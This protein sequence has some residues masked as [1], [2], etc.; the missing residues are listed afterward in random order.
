MYQYFKA[1]KFNFVFFILLIFIPL[2]VSLKYHSLHSSMMDL[3][4]YLFHFYGMSLGEWEWIFFGHNQPFHLPYFFIYSQLPVNFSPYAILIIQSFFLLLPIYFF[5]L[6]CGRI[7]ALAYLLY[8]PL[9]FNLLFDFHFDHLSVLFL[10]LFFLLVKLN[11]F[12][13]AVFF[14]IILAF[15]KEPFALQTAM[16][17]FY[18]LIINY[19]S[20]PNTKLLIY[21]I[22][23][24]FF[25]FGFFY[26]SLN[27]III[28][29]SSIYGYSAFSGS[30]FSY[31]GSSLN[32]ILV[33]I[34]T[35]PSEILLDIFSTPR[36]LLFIFALFGSLAFI[37]LLNPAPLIVALP[38]F[39]ISLLSQSENYYALGHHYTA[40]LIA[41]MI[42]SFYG[43]INRAKL[44]WS[45]ITLFSLKFFIPSITI[46]LLVAHILLSPS[47]ISRLF[48]S[49]KIWSYNYK[50]YMI[51]ERD[52]MIINAIKEHI[53]SDPDKLISVQNNINWHPLVQ[54]RHFLLFPQ[55]IIKE[56]NVPVF[57][58][59]I[60]TFEASWNSVKADYA[61]VDL[62]RP[63]FIED[64]GC[65]WFYDTCTNK[66]IANN[67]LAWIEKT[68][69]NMEVI[70]EKDGFII[71]QRVDY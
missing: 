10:S 41:P 18:L 32:E 33:N 59:N 4:L 31:L 49:D 48:W 57:D 38:I 35:N 34:F 11:K 6:H 9:W 61:V 7:V 64:K 13:L 37:P 3:G 15:V 16:C 55:G 62:K 36:K 52:F 2:M 69:N 53:P 23:L 12:G 28:S 66:I 60:K 25:G 24:I 67:F 45:N 21:S 68:R 8:F 54:R 47:P 1:N 51:Q 22:G 27:S 70:F 50:A 19:K 58:R 46:V 20:F 17:G 29:S 65:D 39:A 26:F 43:G 63:W 30:A 14:A 44:I 5:H 56:Q 71:F 42:Y 40:G